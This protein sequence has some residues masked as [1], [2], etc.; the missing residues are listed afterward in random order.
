MVR[1]CESEK[2]TLRLAIKA[3]Y[4]AGVHLTARNRRLPHLESRAVDALNSD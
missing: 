2:Q 1:G 3:E 4:C